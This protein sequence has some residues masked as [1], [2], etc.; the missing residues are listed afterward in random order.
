MESKSSPKIGRNEPCPCNSG[1]KY[2]KCCGKNIANKPVQKKTDNTA[3]ANKALQLCQS[4]HFNKAFNLCQS[5]LEVEPANIIA[6]QL[7]CRM[8]A[9]KGQQDHAISVVKKAIALKPKQAEFYFVLGNARK[10]QNQIDESIVQFNKSIELNPNM[11]ETYV[12]RASAFGLQGRIDE[13]IADYQMVLSINPDFEIANINI[14]FMLNLSTKFSDADVVS[15]H[16]RVGKLIESHYAVEPSA[17][18]SDDRKK[19]RL[20]VGYVSSDFFTHSVVYFIAPVLE[21]HN[22]RDFEIFAYYTN[23]IVDAAT[24]KLKAEC[25]NWRNVAA[26]NDQ[27]FDELIRND[28]IDI[29]VDLSG[30]TANTRIQVFARKPAPIQVA[31]IG[32]PNTTG[33]ARMDYRIT[34]MVADPPGMDDLY[35]EQLYRM[36]E[37]FSVYQPPDICPEVSELPCLKNDVITFGS[38]NNFSKTN[39]TVIALWS[40]LLI[41]IPDARLLLKNQALGDKTMQDRVYDA[42]LKH[43]INPDRLILFGMDVDK[44]IHFQRY[45]QVDIGLDPFPYNGTTTTCEALWMGVPVVTLAGDSHRARVGASLLTTI[46]HPEWIAETT[47]EYIAIAKELA[48]NHEAL[49]GLRMNLRKEMAESPLTDAKAF[50][51]NLEKAYKDIWQ[52]QF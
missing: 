28:K 19:S 12:N 10:F 49:S 38:F 13:A 17:P 51:L 16:H 15:E 43:G 9:D 24:Q 36:P 45:G 42:F 34:D 50:T 40:K 32:Y 33:L 8:L 5:I 7:L 2:K 1:K 48:S 31:W 26:L 25:D 23:T 20:R 6:V 27:Q 11:V 3:A 35:T 52:K 30:Y 41:E 39:S 37:N 29:L 22:H 14:L 47:D 4:G 18:I 44:T 46:N 21:N